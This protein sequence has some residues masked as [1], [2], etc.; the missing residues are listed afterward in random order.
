MSKH[1][2]HCNRII[3]NEEL[4]YC[5]SCYNELRKNGLFKENK[6]KHCKICGRELKDGDNIKKELCNKHFQQIKKYGFVLDDNQRNESDLNEYVEF[7]KHYEMKL[8]D[9]LQEE[10]EDKV[11][12]DKDDYEL[13]KDIRW[14]KNRICVTA[15]INGKIIPLQNYILN[16]DEQINFVSQD[17]LDCR[18]NNLYVKKKKDKKHKIKK[19][20]DNKI[21]ISFIGGSR[22]NVTGSSILFEYPKKDETMG[23]FLVENGMI[24]GGTILEDY[25][26]NS[27][28][29]EHTPYED[30]EFILLGH[31]HID[32]V[33]LLPASISRGFKG[34]IYGTKECLAICDKLLLDTSYIHERNLED[35]NKGGKKYK[36]IFTES[37]TYMT[38]NKFTPLPKHEIIKINEYVSV[39]LLNNSHCFGACQIVI[40]IKKPSNHVFKC[41]ITSDLGNEN[42]FEYQPFVDRNELCNKADVMVIEGTYGNR[43]SFSKKECKDERLDLIK[44]IKQVIDNKH[45]VLIPCFSF[46]RTQMCLS[47][48]YE[49]FKNVDL[50]DT[51]IVCDSKLSNEINNVF[52]NTLNNEDREYFREVL[53]WD[54]LKC[55]TSFKETE[56]IMKRKNQPLIVIASSGMCENGRSKYWCKDI[57]PKKDDAIFFIG[58]CGKN[59]LGN[60][61]QN[62]NTKT[63][64][65]DG[66]SYPKR[67]KI[68]VYKTFS[69]HAQQIDLINYIKHINIGK[70]IL[71]HH[72]E[73]DAKNVLYDVANEE[74]HR[75]GKSTK[76]IPVKKGTDVF[77]I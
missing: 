53:S 60:R 2:I 56:K 45:R 70:M 43:P 72:A 51:M 39:E 36:P 22:D 50:G 3:E 30:I 9:E 76:I 44:E 18:R 8:Y 17:V 6:K 34:D 1:C 52:L 75:I 67:C 73:E 63:I 47:M 10:L 59:T 35:I 58:Y 74:L 64:T 62:E 68:K 41:L 5:E 65:I 66:V 61:I 54:R 23:T 38:I 48:L 49:N 14:D 4:S 42:S 24:Q 20:K 32:H 7:P 71:I 15:K 13:I 57:L 26:S 33:G 37:D 29:A 77:V 12:I 31:E 69:S 11:L 25:K 28:L 16:T 55:I 46:Q 27:I 21:R 19:N 40:Y